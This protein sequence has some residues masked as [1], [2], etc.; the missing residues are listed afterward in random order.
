MEFIDWQ[1]LWKTKL[2][3]ACRDNLNT[4]NFWNKRA[5]NF[6]EN[7]TE[8]QTL[9]TSQLERMQLKPEYT[10]LDVGAGSG[11]L[12]LPIAK[13]VK[14][15]TAVEPSKNM[16]DFLVS[17]AKKQNIQ[18]IT[19][20]NRSCQDLLLEEETQ[21]HDVVFASFSLFMPD[22]ADVLL[23]M[24]ELATKAVYLFLSASQ[25]MNDELQQ[26]VNN[27]V[28][29]IK[30]SDYIFIY[31]ILHD[32]GILANV[33]IW[34]SPYTY[35]YDSL[36]DAVTKFGESYEVRPEKKAELK[37]FLNKHLVKENGKFLL[38]RDRKVAMVWWT[39]I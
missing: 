22:I 25:W 15:V 17:N 30:A 21:P 2:K 19:I 34:D 32:L 29:P 23:H 33:E 12:A 36:D 20:V 39:K 37:I 14:H 28:S 35:S 13:R 7:M 9:T 6:N 27:T 3:L 18:N 38:K 8:M 31:N 26:I 5:K 4:V 1:K 24:N 11:R 16:Y 10:V